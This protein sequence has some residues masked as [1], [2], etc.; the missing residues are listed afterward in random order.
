MVKMGMD[1]DETRNHRIRGIIPTEDNKYLFIEILQGTR[2]NRRDISLSKKEYQQ[3]YPNEEYIWIDGCFR[4]DIPEDYTKN[5]TSEFEKYDRSSFPELR[6]TKENIV[7][8]LKQF[9]KD[10]DDIE[11]TNDDYIDKFCEKKG[12]FGLYD[13]RLKHSYEPVEI[14]WFNIEVNRKSV[15][16]FLYTCYASNGIKYTEEMQRKVEMSDL[17][18]KYGK[19]KV[20]RLIDKYIETKCSKISHSKIREDYIKGKNELFENNQI[21]SNDNIDIDY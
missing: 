18:N 7:K 3:K 5:Y 14:I 21:G 11:L 2:P 4:V 20:E 13:C 19:E 1:I 8:L 15:V 16:K 17:I 10:I 12:F 6:H 9:N